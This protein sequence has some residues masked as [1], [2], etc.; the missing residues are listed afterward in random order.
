MEAWKRPP[1]SKGLG[2][3]VKT[4]KMMSSSENAGKVILVLFVERALAVIP[5]FASFADAG[6]TRD[7]VVLKVN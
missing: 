1:E 4:R 3:N 6:C 7:V 2:V 5:S